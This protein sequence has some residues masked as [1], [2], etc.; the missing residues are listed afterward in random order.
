MGKSPTRKGYCECHIR[1]VERGREIVLGRMSKHG[2]IWYAEEVIAENAQ[3]GKAIKGRPAHSW[4]YVF[5]GGT[6]ANE[7]RCM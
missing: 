1:G 4:K 5:A 2:E 3:W 7:L 6:F